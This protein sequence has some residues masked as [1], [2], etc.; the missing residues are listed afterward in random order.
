MPWPSARIGRQKGMDWGQ[1]VGSHATSRHPCAARSTQRP[2]YASCPIRQLPSSPQ[3]SPVARSPKLPN[4][5]LPLTSKCLLALQYRRR[6]GRYGSGGGRGQQR[7]Q[8]CTRSTRLKVLSGAAGAAQ[9]CGQAKGC[10]C[11]ACCARHARSARH[12]HRGRLV[13][14]ARGDCIG[15]EGRGNGGG[16]AARSAAQD[17]LGRVRHAAKPKAKAPATPGCCRCQQQARR[18]MPPPPPA[19]GAGGSPE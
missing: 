1:F 18:C 17:A 13:L 12:T 8:A 7:M 10:P 15:R 3:L 9:H 2:Q 16:R 11:C 14:D 6:Q 5:L 4:T 19:A